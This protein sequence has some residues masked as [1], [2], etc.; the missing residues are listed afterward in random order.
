V[1]FYEAARDKVH[2]FRRFGWQGELFASAALLFRGHTVCSLSI[3]VSRK[4]RG[5]PPAIL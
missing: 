3:W 5:L 1:F 2:S 4:Q